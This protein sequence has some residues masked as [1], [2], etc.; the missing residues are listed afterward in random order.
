MRLT[1]S[2][3]FPGNILRAAALALIATLA[4]TS[5]AFA[6]NG[7]VGVFGGGPFY[8]NATNNIREIQNSG[9]TEAIVWSVEV[10]SNGDLNLN[11]EFPLTSGGAYIGGQTHPDFAGNMSVLKQG[12]VKRVTLSIGSS[13]VGDWQDITALVNAQ[14]TGPGSILYQ[15]FQVLKAAIPALDAV[16]FDDENSFD[17]TTTV[18][19]G[20]MLG[21]LGYHVIPDAYN[22]S[23]Y[24]M[25]VVTGINSQLPGTVDS[26]H[27]QAYAGGAGNNP[28]SSTWNFG[29][30]PVYPGLWDKAETPK[31]VQSRIAN[32]H[33]Q[34]G[35]SG[36]FMWIYDDF[37]GNGKAAQYAQA[38]KVGAGYSGF[39][40]SGPATVYVNQNASAKGTIKIADLGG[41]AGTVNLSVA[42]LPSGIT[43]SFG[44][45]G[46]TQK[47]TFKAAALAP[48]GF[49]PIT[50]TGTSGSITQDF[51][52]T[53]AVSAAKGT[54]GSGQEVDLS[55]AFNLFG[56][57]TDGT[58]FSTGGLD[59]NGFAYSTKLLT[60]SRSLSQVRFKFGLANS[61]DA[62]SCN[63]ELISLP[64]GNYSELILL[65][66]GVNGNQGPV[67]ITV[68]YTD[69]T[70]AQFLQSFSDWSTPQHYGGEVEGVAMSYRDA[71]NGTKNDGIFNLYGYELTLN[72][73]KAVQSVILPSDPNV[74]V[75]AATLVP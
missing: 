71:A 18:E 16:D 61:P 42:V 62:V 5:A 41:F 1:R 34:C 59:G 25:N 11:G 7:Y 58:T 4:L 52:L 57:Y 46:N 73:A 50:V 70:S 24:W 21:N 75:L 48:T 40:L 19:F 3:H 14:G 33:S 2:L 15:D 60:K 44:G 55:A 22:N 45:T 8:I 56:I 30:V 47:V 39:A 17:L 27:L 63:G 54:K 72:P 23:S 6:Q 65:G 9:F 74:V 68:N 49:F 31:E 20:V 36:G 37:V 32:W 35:I 43:V 53:L 66:T 64:Q 10:K 12:N 26:V 38:M 51:T 67:T 29:A 28:C 13:N 69:G